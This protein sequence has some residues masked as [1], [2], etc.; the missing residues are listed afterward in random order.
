MQADY[1]LIVNFAYDWFV[2]LPVPFFTILLP[3]SFSMGSLYDAMVR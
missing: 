3:I 1:D 2:V